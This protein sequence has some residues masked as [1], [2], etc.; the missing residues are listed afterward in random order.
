LFT[1]YGK[2]DAG[3]KTFPH[4]PTTISPAAQEFL[5]TATPFAELAETLEQWQHVRTAFADQQRELNK[6]AKA[7]FVGESDAREIA[8]VPVLVVTPQNYDE[9][10]DDRIAIYTHGG[11]YTLARPTELYHAFAPLAAATGLRVFAIDYR[12]APDHPFPAGLNDSLA[13]YKSLLSAYKA[14]DVV[15]FGDSAGAG[16]VLTSMLKARD[17]GLELPAAIALYSPWADITKTGDSYY[18]LEGIATTLH[19]E[20]N[21]RGSAL[22]YAGEKDMHN[23][24]VSPVYGDYSQRFPPTLIQVGTRD[25]FLSNCARL[26]RKMSVDGVDVELSLWEGMWHVFEADPDLPEAQDAIAEAAEYL[27]SHLGM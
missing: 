7:R 18:T 2:A 8:G 23:P 5:R 10:N 21:L 20:K 26:Y 14:K 22:A 13:V 16:M 25:L 24:L 3:M 15:I 17:I 11:A 4:V 27:N 12:L 19:Y 9:A 6:M 1:F